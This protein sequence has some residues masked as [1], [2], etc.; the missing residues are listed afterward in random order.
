MRATFFLALALACAALA[1]IVP[2]TATAAGPPLRIVQLGDSYS[3]G[4]GAGELLGAERLLSQHENWAEKYL[5]MLGRRARRR[6]STA[7]ARAAFSTTSPTPAT[8]DAKHARRVRAGEAVTQDDPARPPTLD[9]AGHCSTSYRD[10]EV[11]GQSRADV[12]RSPTPAAR[13]SPLVAH[14]AMEP[15]MEC[16]RHGA[17]TSSC[18]RSAATTSALRRSSSIASSSACVT[19]RHCREKVTAAQHGHRRC[20]A[21]DRS[22]SCGRSRLQMRPDAKIVLK[23]YPY[24][25]KDPNFELRQLASWVP[26]L[27]RRRPRDPPARRSRRRSASGRLWMRST[28]RAAPR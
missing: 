18:S 27:L 2:S 26:R 11:V 1:A 20:R 5:D 9:R 7:H 4:N 23:A 24:L 25:E 13:R 21:A 6:S 22:R 8:M 10:D 14:A 3:A 12:P 15:Q 28:P 19:R 16:G 17:P